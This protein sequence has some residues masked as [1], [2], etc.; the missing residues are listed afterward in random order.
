MNERVNMQ[1][2]LTYF[3]V[4]GLSSFPQMCSTGAVKTRGV[5]F[6]CHV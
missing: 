2:G 5:M 4:A 6:A 3:S 1:I